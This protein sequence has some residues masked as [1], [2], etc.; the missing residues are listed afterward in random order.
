MVDAFALFFMDSVEIGSVGWVLL[1]A[2]DTVGVLTVAFVY[3]CGLRETHAV[4]GF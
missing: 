4:W 1:G 3:A 2:L